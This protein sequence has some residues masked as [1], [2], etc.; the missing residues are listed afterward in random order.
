[1]ASSRNPLPR[2]RRDGGTRESILDDLI[3]D[4]RFDNSAERCQFMQWLVVP[5]AFLTPA[6]YEARGCAK[7]PLK[8]I[9]THP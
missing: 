6:E 7:W 8:D 1:M 9:S 2:T 5:F 4:P 3:E